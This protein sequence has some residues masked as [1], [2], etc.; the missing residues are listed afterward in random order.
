MC[1]I[2]KIGSSL[3]VND[4]PQSCFQITKEEEVTWCSVWAAL[5]GG[6][7]TLSAF[8][9]SIFSEESRELCPGALSR[10]RRI[11]Y[12]S[13]FFCGSMSRYFAGDPE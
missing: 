13:M 12:P 9:N 5:Y 11:E 1:H 10:W 4:L 2:A 7:D 6:C 3:I 8:A